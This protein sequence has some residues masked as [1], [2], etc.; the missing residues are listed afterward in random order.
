MAEHNFIDL[1]PGT[2]DI[3]SF[4]MLHYMQNCLPWFIKD[5]D[6][7]Y[8]EHSR[9]MPLIFKSEEHSLSGKTDCELNLMTI[10]F[11]RK[12]ERIRRLVTRKHVR[13]MSLEINLFI[14]ESYFTPLLF[15]T[16]PFV[17]KNNIFTI[18]KLS[19][20]Y[21]L[22]RLSFSPYDC[23]SGRSVS[24]DTMLEKP[25]SFFNDVNPLDIVSEQQWETL[26]MCLMGNSYRKIS[27]LT[28]RNLKN[29]AEYINR[30]F[31]LLGVH[32]LN[33]FLYVSGLYGW[34][35]YIPKSIQKREH[36]RIL[37]IESP[38]NDLF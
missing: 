13:I 15:I 35:R 31:K 11:Q 28:G 34:E 27:M 8:L 14:T 29:T 9:H 32:T 36:S 37:K 10:S 22:R 16:E 26:W 6:G 1:R 18:T 5:T 7:R 12:S 23:F 20:I 3:S 21:A 19:D 17:Y 24:V 2:Q 4:F 30:A 38:S 33:N 25:V